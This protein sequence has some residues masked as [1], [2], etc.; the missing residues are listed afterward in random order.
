M[1]L[2]N[3]YGGPPDHCLPIGT[4]EHWPN[5]QIFGHGG[6]YK[7]FSLTLFEIDYQRHPE[8]KKRHSSL[9]LL[10]K[11]FQTSI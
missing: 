1:I 6:D 3:A 11:Y 4:I 5:Q 2:Y 9:Y 7:D 10:P 8:I